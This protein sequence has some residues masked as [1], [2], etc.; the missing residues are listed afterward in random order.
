MFF[1]LRQFFTLTHLNVCRLLVIVS[2]FIVVTKFFRILNVNS[3]TIIYGYLKMTEY[4]TM[5]AFMKRWLCCITWIV[6]QDVLK[7]QKLTHRKLNRKYALGLGFR[8][9]LINSWSLY[10]KAMF[11]F[12]F[13]HSLALKFVISTYWL[14]VI[15]IFIK[16]IV[17]FNKLISLCWIYLTWGLLHNLY[18]TYRKTE[19]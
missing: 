8:S 15:I 18:S 2:H 6:I 7:C 17:M 10:R 14:F 1:K 19:A 4:R 16:W 3:V 11:I 13:Y 5:F 9:S 12:S